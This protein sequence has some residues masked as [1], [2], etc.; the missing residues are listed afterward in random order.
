M[1]QI[2]KQYLFPLIFVLYS[3]SVFAL[4]EDRT[5]KKA[6]QAFEKNNQAALAQYAMQL[7]DKHYH[8][9]PYAEYWLAL[10]RMGQMS[11]QQVLGLVQRTQDYAFNAQLR[12]SLLK[13]LAKSGQWSIFD[14]QQ[15]HYKGSNVAVACLKLQR[16]SQLHQPVDVAAVRTLWLSEKRQAGECN[17]LF[18]TMIK[19]GVITR[20]N[21][22]ERVRLALFSGR[23]RLAK[24]IALKLPGVTSKVSR[25]V[26]RVKKNPKRFL[27]KRV[28]SFSK[29]FG[30]ELN[31][32]AIDRVAR[33]NAS[34]AA[35]LLKKVQHLFNKSNRA[36]AWQRIAYRAAKNLQPRALS[37]Y[38]MV[39]HASPTPDYLMTH[40]VYLEENAWHARAAL[41]AEKWPYL[42]KVIA[43]MPVSQA[44]RAR[45][46]Y[47]KAR[48][49]KAH[50]PKAQDQLA[51]ADDLLINLG[52][53]RH[54]YGWLA[55]EEVGLAIEGIGSNAMDSDA[56]QVQQIASLP[57]IH[58]AATLFKLGLYQDA[59]KEWYAAIKPLTDSERLSAATY[60]QKIGWNDV[61]INTAD[62]TTQVH[63]FNLRYPTPYR[64]YFQQAAANANLD[65]AWVFGLV[66]QESRFMDYA[67]SRVGASGLMQ[68][69]PKT[70]RWVAK[71]M[72]M[73]GYSRKKI[74]DVRT[75]VELGTFYMHHTLE[76]MRGQAVMA[77][78]AYNAGPSRALKWQANRPLEAAIYME[79]IPFNETRNYVQRVMANAHLYAPR[80][81]AVT[82]TLKQRIGMIPARGQ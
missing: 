37:Y 15:A 29:P 74:H 32:F 67:K 59:R 25:L 70:A 20:K 73:R 65:P 44:N 62:R 80:I 58:R 36:V 66:R 26:D 54:Y 11:N 1:N 9:A 35:G 50:Y 3:T 69:M 60:A 34:Q 71:K 40:A 24:S 16:Q 43:K 17:A 68:L 48:A 53:E 78:A 75:N 56:H 28:A 76:Q 6:H 30:A 82:Q 8:L 57:K 39:K 51:I 81:G 49:L 52:A 4:F 61:S 2:V 47:W 63:N 21:K 33:K 19:S 7:S 14:A 45:W 31:L 22:Y 41:R 18:D 13:K 72:G 42:L 23:T 27:R 10:K 64:Q 12:V 55:A 38:A 79:T 77:T 46:R 5:F